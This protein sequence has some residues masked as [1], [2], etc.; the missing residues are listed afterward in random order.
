MH[1]L[2]RSAVPIG[3]CRIGK[4]R[5]PGRPRFIVTLLGVGGIH[6]VSLFTS[7]PGVI[8]ARWLI[9]NSYPRATTEI[10]QTA[11]QRIRLPTVEDQ[12]WDAYI[13]CTPR[14]AAGLTPPGD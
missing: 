11:G 12:C 14:L 9:P 1:S 3:T 5:G 10:R 8:L 4:I 7:P 6:L 13:P 2:S